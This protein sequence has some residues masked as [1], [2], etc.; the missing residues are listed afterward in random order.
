MTNT[1]EIGTLPPLLLY[2]AMKIVLGGAEK[3]RDRQIGLQTDRQAER[4]KRRK[5]E[6]KYGEKCKVRGKERERTQEKETQ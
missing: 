4:K 6:I 1:K 3:G 2:V 5:V